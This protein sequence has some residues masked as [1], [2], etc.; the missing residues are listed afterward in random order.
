MKKL[1]RKQ[2]LITIGCRPPYLAIGTET[3]KCD[4]V[5]RLNESR[6]Q[7]ERAREMDYPKDCKRMS[8]IRTSSVGGI[9]KSLDKKWRFGI[10]YPDEVKIITQSKE[11]DIHTLIGNIGGYFGLFL[12]KYDRCILHI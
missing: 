1:V 8:G 7:Y 9:L 5:K 6:F 11:V 10:S 3:P 4:T 12:G 2:H